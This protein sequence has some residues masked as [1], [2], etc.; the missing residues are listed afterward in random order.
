MSRKMVDCRDVPSESGCTLAIAGEEDE[1]LT[2]AVWPA[3]PDNGH[4]DTP[5]F[6]ALIRGGMKDAE[7]AL[8]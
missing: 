7:G 1:L 4:E 5:E 8:A 6:R 2:V 3:V